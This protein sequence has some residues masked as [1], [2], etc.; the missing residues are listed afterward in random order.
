M[1]P[2]HQA[3][4]PGEIGSLESILGLL[5]KF[6]N[7]GSSGP[8]RQPYSYLVPSLIDFQNLLHS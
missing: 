7:S 5:K 1:V 4:Q 2:A 6:N 8:V 3:T